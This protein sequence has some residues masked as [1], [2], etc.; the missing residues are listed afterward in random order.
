MFIH[1]KRRVLYFTVEPAIAKKQIFDEECAQ[2]MENTTN[3]RPEIMGGMNAT[4]NQH[5][6]FFRV[7]NYFILFKNNRRK[8]YFATFKKQY[9]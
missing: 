6:R 8:H 3:D 4:D 9:A 2:L 1:I 7:Y 5:L